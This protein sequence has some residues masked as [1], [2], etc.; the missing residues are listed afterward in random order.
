MGYLLFLIGIFLQGG[1]HR[2]TSQEEEEEGHKA[3]D[4]EEG[5]HTTD[6]TQP[7]L[8]AIGQLLREQHQNQTHQG[9]KD[10]TED[11]GPAETNRSTA[12]QHTHQSSQE[13]AAQQGENQY[14]SHN[15]HFLRFNIIV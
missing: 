4:T 3:Q 7:L 6:A 8:L 10:Q 15:Y 1:Q 2:T 13:T 11:K 9:R 12:T 5:Q 14:K